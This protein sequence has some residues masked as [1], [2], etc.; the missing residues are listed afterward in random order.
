MT[1]TVTYADGHVSVLKTSKD[2]DILLEQALREEQRRGV[3]REW[4][5]EK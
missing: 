2:K 4:R 3:A 5:R 1:Y